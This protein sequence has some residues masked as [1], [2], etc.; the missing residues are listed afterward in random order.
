MFTRKSVNPN[1][2]RRSGK[3][4]GETE[5]SEGKFSEV[6]RSQ[7]RPLANIS[8]LTVP[9]GKDEAVLVKNRRLIQRYFA[10]LRLLLKTF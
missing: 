8:Q 1:K 10:A 4:G 9:L 7:A 3:I 2:W 5:N 6:R